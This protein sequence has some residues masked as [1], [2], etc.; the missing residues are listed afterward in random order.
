MKEL[1]ISK[2]LSAKRHEKGIT[3]EEIADY[4]GVSKA[5]V[6]KWETGQSYPDI[7]YLPQLA[8]YFNISID[9]LIGYE[10]QMTRQNIVKLYKKIRENFVNKP[11]DE[12]ITEIREY[13][14]KYYSCFP[15]LFYMGLLMVNHYMLAKPEQQQEI[16]CE[17]TDLFT[18]IRNESDD[19]ELCKQAIGLEASCLYMRNEPEKVIELL[20][21]VLNPMINEFTILSLAYSMNGD[22]EKAEEALQISL[23]QF[24]LNCISALQ[25]MLPFCLQDAERFNEV[26][27][28]IRSLVKIFKLE[29]LHPASMLT[30]Y[31]TMAVLY[32]QKGDNKK[33]IEMLNKYCNL[34]TSGIFPLELHGDSFFDKING[35]LEGLDLGVEP[36]RDDKIIRQST[37]DAVDICPAFSIHSDNPQYKSIMKRL[38]SIVKGDSH[39]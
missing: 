20:D 19:I 37:I 3:Q 16:I 33:S 1:N 29:S 24:V 27:E 26:E 5:S 34:A 36:P 35:W 10:P 38:K 21:N 32:V 14:K 8:A 30:L 6:S 11:Y 28:K 31:V 13:I 7:T 2:V 23:Y 18:R 39:G 17:A 22:N 9:E 4:I 15:L 12:V 25:G